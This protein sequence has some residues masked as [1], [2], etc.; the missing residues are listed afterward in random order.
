M[1]TVF[2]RGGL[3]NQMFQYALGLHLAKRNH[4]DLHFDTTFLHDR[5]PRRQ[6]TYRTFDLDIFAID[7]RFTALSKISGTVPIPGL[8]LGA[9]LA[10]A[11]VKDI[12]GTQRIIR[13]KKD[14]VFDPAVLTSPS[15]VFLYGFWQSEKYFAAIA[16]DVRQAFRFRY[17]LEGEATN[18][19]DQIAATNA[20]SVNVRRG[21]YLLS[22][23]LK[24][25]GETGLSYYERAA[26][27]I[28]ERIRDPHFFV[29]SDDVA[30]CRE[31]LRLGFPTTYVS[32]ASG[33][34]KQNFHLQL[35]S[36]CKH[37]II[38][39]STFGWWGAWLNRSPS[40]IVVAPKIWHSGMENDDIVPKEWIRL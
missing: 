4:A 18:F 30:W 33:G 37:H 1:I 8:W 13:E 19:A 21:D 2:L 7:P 34:Y 27:Y 6:F 25:L 22:A 28:A 36:Q 5:F 10:S 32:A 26:A 17:P 11:S 29:V 38:T 31:H 3:G 35:I 23:N 16:E 39:N 24:R 14:G 9:D 40:K 20:V 12:F 15:S